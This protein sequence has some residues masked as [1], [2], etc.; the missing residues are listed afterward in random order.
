LRQKAQP[1][2]VEQIR[3]PAVQKFIDDMIETM[4]EYD[5]A[6]LAGNQVHEPVQIAVIE[7]EANPRYPEA[8]S[9]E[10][11]CAVCTMASST[12]LPGNASRSRA[13]T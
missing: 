5:G 11:A 10:M 9:R 3:S 7:V 13:R 12:M 4:H 1:L 8:A 6:G 2:S